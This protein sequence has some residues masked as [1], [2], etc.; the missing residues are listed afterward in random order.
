MLRILG[1][2]PSAMQERNIKDQSPLHISATWPRGIQILLE[3]GGRQLVNQADVGGWIPVSYALQNC[4]YQASKLLFSAGS[5][6]TSPGW[7]GEEEEALARPVL[8]RQP[9]LISLAIDALKSR[10]ME[11]YEMAKQ[12]LPAKTWNELDLPDDHVLD[13]KASLVQDALQYVGIEVPATLVVRQKG[14][15]V[16]HYIGFSVEVMELLF[17]AGFHDIDSADSYGLTPFQSQCLGALITLKDGFG[18]LNFLVSKGIDPSLQFQNL[19][20]FALLSR[21]SGYHLI[22]YFLGRTLDNQLFGNQLFGLSSLKSPFPWLRSHAR[23]ILD[24]IDKPSRSLVRKT[25]QHCSRD[26]CICACSHNGCS[27]VTAMLKSFAKSRSFYDGANL[28]PAPFVRISVTCWLENEFIAEKTGKPPMLVQDVIRFETFEALGLKHTCCQTLYWSEAFTM[29]CEAEEIWEIREE[30]HDLI[31][32]LEQLVDNFLRSYDERGESLSEFLTG[33]WRTRMAA[34]LTDAQ[35]ADNEELGRIR[36]IGVVIEECSTLSQQFAADDEWEVSQ[37]DCNSHFKGN[38]E[39]GGSRDSGDDGSPRDDT[40]RQETD[41]DHLE[42]LMQDEVDVSGNLDGAL[43]H[44]AMKERI[45][46]EEWHQILRDYHRPGDRELPG[47]FP[48]PPPPPPLY[49]FPASPP[50]L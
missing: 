4:N 42:P 30:E 23:A 48:P 17:K 5:A 9:E 27:P 2:N 43:N 41:L 49:L 14:H 22:G 32:Q 44:S 8:L 7:K 15:S 46:D 26:S 29:R 35:P 10:R 31:Q 40:H 34:V 37:E 45:S 24:S 25:I 20:P 36:D 19:S 28:Y 1:E 50:L 11:L 38:S 33:H 47:R 18:R 21:V 16:Y 12:L 13:Q 39:K 6:L 3:H